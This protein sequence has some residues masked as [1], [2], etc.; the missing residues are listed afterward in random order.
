MPIKMTS[1]EAAGQFTSDAGLEILDNLKSCPN[2]G[3]QTYTDRAVT[4]KMPG[5]PGVNRA[6]LDQ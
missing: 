3:A 5:S 2:C 6:G 1:Y 4:D